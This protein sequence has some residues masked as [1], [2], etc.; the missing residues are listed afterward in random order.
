M[1]RILTNRLNLPV[2][3]IILLTLIWGSS[4]ILIKKSLDVFTP[5][6][7]A[8]CRIGT[9]GICMLPFSISAFRQIPRTSWKYL[10]LSAL[11]GTII[12]FT[13]FGVALL[14]LSSSVTGILN[15]L[16]P[17]FTFL[18]GTLLF[19]E[20]FQKEKIGGLFLGFFGTVF[21]I[22][23]N[24][25]GEFGSLNYWAFLIVLA[26]F[27][28]GINANITMK[29]LAGLPTL[30]TVTWIL[31]CLSPLAWGYLLFTDFSE[32]LTSHPNGW[33]AFFFICILGAVGTAFAWI[34]FVRI[35]QMKSAI[36]ASTVT[37]LIPIVALL[38]GIWDG[39][40]LHALQLIGC[41]GIVVGVYLTNR[42][43]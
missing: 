33:Q 15:A 8:M 18:V 36:Y 17:L 22:L 38:W 20:Q 9:A 34:L 14:H 3:F 32:R 4:F 11:M 35:V 42:K 40:Q 2:F 10:G 31:T 26:T 1:Y 19:K 28:Y 43:R 24:S 7:L 16:T 23:V 37:Y 12:P 27:C 25:D 6:Q 13:I 41:L 30:S 21:I 29:Y 39:E 5:L